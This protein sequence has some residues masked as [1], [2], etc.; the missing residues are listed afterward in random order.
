VLNSLGSLFGGCFYQSKF[1]RKKIN[2]F[3]LKLESIVLFL[4]LSS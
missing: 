1:G 4:T 3:L 2:P